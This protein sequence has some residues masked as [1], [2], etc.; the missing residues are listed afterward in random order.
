M[1]GKF[2]GKE[3][4]NVRKKEFNQVASPS[5]AK[6]RS[7]PNFFSTTAKI[8]VKKIAENQRK[9]KELVTIQQQETVDKL[10]IDA[11]YKEKAILQQ[12]KQEAEDIL[13]VTFQQSEKNVSSS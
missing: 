8:I 6:N 5:K 7:R 12:A 9:E 4:F 3:L 13:T 11:S 2:E 10:V 1:I